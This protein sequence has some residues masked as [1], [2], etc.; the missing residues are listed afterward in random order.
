MSD[1]PA[2]K[3]ILSSSLGKELNEKE[4]EILATAMTVRRLNDK[5]LLIEKDASDDSLFLLACGELAVIKK[6][7]AKEASVVYIM[8]EGEC[9]GTRAFVDRTPRKATLRAQGNATVYVM[10]PDNFENLLDTHPRIVYKVMRAIFRITH[11]NL[12][13]M[14]QESAQ[15]SN[16]INKT[17]GRY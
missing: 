7:G 16:Y 12:M 5:E 2:A 11:S 8:K 13:R 3:L 4:C 6:G 15:L 10:T 14:N 1:T 9:A 17:H